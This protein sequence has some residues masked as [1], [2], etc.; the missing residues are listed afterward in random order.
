MEKMIGT[1]QIHIIPF[2]LGYVFYDVLSINNATNLKFAKEFVSELSKYF[3]AHEYIKVE[4]NLSVQFSKNKVI[5]VKYPKSEIADQAIGIAKLTDSLYC[6]ILA[7][8]IGVFVLA[9]CNR[10]AM[11]NHYQHVSGYNKAI[12]ASYQKK[13]SQ[14][15]ILNRYEGSDVFPLEEK[16]MLE[17]RNAC[18]KIAPEIASKSKYRIKKARPLSSDIAYKSEGFSYVLTAY[19]INKDEM[20]QKEI[21]YL[22]YAS[23]PK[24]LEDKQTLDRIER[25]I[26]NSDYSSREVTSVVGSTVLHFSWSAVAA[27]MSNDINTYEDIVNSP[28]LSALIKTEIY[29]QSRWF[30]AD[31]SLDNVNKSFNCKLEELQKIESL[32]EFYQAELDNEISANMNTLQKNILSK[33]VET[34]SVKPL[35]KSVL[36]Q[37]Q[38]QRKIKVAHDQDVKKRNSLILNLFMAI[39]TASSLFKTLLDIINDSFSKTNIVLFGTMLALAVG[40]ILFDY[41]NNK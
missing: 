7:N 22:M 41:Y 5:K 26:T 10:V 35:Y 12:V 17:F 13:L 6:Y 4:D 15:T 40:T 14:A 20:C 39:F 1:T 28:S 16:L 25:D 18:W 37:I 34:S 2:D 31:N 23:F 36:S 29:V 11:K 19:V 32:T 33:V 9:D 38:T 21:D 8:G 3:S 27:I 24:K 30:I